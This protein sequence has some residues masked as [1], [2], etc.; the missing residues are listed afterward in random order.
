MRAL[1]IMNTVL[2]GGYEVA[3]IIITHYITKLN[4]ILVFKRNT[5]PIPL[6]WA[7]KKF[8]D[9]GIPNLPSGQRPLGRFGLPRSGNLYCRP[10]SG[11]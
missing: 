6:H 1:F 8:P 2:L 3:I 9:L 10:S 5:S 7:A 11:V 4:Y